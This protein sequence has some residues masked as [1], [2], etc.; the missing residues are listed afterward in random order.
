[1][2]IVNEQYFNKKLIQPSTGVELYTEGDD[3]PFEAWIDEYARLC[4]QNALGAVLFDDFDSDVSNG[5]LKSTAQDKWKNLVNG[6]DY[7]YNGKDYRW[8]GLIYTEGKSK[9]SLL[10]DFVFA[11]WY[12][13]EQSRLSAMGEATGNSINAMS[14]SGNAKHCKIWNEFVRAYQGNHRY[15]SDYR[16]YWTRFWDISYNTDYYRYWV[17]YSQ[18][19]SYVSLVDFIKHNNEDY[20]EP[21]LMLYGLKNVMSL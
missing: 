2:Y 18:K 9:K 1:M 10:A 12:K 13:F 15:F 6:V 7:S 3:N 8:K 16:D 19:S 21:E 14:V 11:E 20:P 4:L 17:N 5:N